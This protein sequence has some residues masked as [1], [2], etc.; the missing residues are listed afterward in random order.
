MKRALSIYLPTFS[1]DHCARKTDNNND[2]AAHDPARADRV[3]LLT[4]E[5]RGREVIARC[6][7]AAARAGV[8]PSQPAAHARALV[9]EKC[10]RIERFDPR[11]DRAA[12]QALAHWAIRISPRVAPD[13]PSGLLLDITGCDRLYKSETRLLRSVHRS[14]ARLGFQSRLAAAPTFAAAAALA[15]FAPGPITVASERHLHNSLAELPLRALALEED[16]ILALDELGVE[17]I[18]QALDLPRAALP[19]RFGDELLHRIDQ[20]F[21]RALETIDAI[22]PAPPL[23]VA[24]LFNGPTKNLEGIMITV[25]ELIETLCAELLRRESGVPRLTLTLT[26]SDL[27]PWSTDIR[28]SRPHRSP[29]HLW[30][31]LQPRVEKAHLGYGVEAVTLHAADIEGIPHEE[32]AL[33]AALGAD[34]PGPHTDRRAAEL[35]DALSGRFGADRVLVARSRESHLPERAFTFQSALERAATGPASRAVTAAPRPTLLYPRPEPA[36]AIAM[37][38]DGPVAR[39]RWR[40]CDLPVA[41][42]IGPERLGGEWWRRSLSRAER[43]RAAGLDGA[44]DYFRIAD[45]SGRWLWVCRALENGRWFVVGEW[46]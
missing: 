9:A 31:L 39:L 37:T 40:G 13:P 17:R 34:A 19:A 5:L 20:T 35:I 38:P 25:R 12:L 29:R 46:A 7:S 33:S 43:D 10:A 36:D 2:D 30:S 22:R 1:T 45:A 28:M 4:E 8:H 23:R 18:G 26:R 15:R 41:M 27:G 42:C 6:C 14:L 21:G 16:V 3:I 32:H 24:R 44:R 11:A